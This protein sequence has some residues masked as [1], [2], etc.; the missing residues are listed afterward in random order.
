MDLKEFIKENKLTFTVGERNTNVTILCG[1]ALHIEATVEDCKNAIEEKYVSTELFQEIE[2]VY[3]YANNNNYG[4]FWIT[5]T[6]Q[7][8]YTF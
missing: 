6:A 8:Q 1:Y 5:E 7:K 2:R 4:D 3:E